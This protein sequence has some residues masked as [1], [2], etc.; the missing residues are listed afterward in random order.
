MNSIVSAMLYFAGVNSIL[1][2]LQYLSA[3]AFAKKIN[4]DAIVEFGEK[5]IKVNH[6]NKDLV[7]IKDWT[8]IKKIETN[9]QLVWLTL[10]QPIPFGISIPRSKLSDSEVELFERM[11][12]Q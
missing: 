12:K 7:E 8:W 5:G 10:N 1:W 6:N 4:F 3:K 11:K 9:K 2:P